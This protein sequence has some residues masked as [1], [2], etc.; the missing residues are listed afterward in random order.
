[1]PS[2]VEKLG[3]NTGKDSDDGHHVAPSNLLVKKNIHFRLDFIP[4]L[5]LK[6]Q[7]FFSSR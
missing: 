6:V 3:S 4:I 2:K 5:T 7:H 1:M